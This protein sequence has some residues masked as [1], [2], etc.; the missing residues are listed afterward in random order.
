MN[1]TL[2]TLVH[3]H[4]NSEQG[5]SEKEMALPKRRQTRLPFCS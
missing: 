5:M 4:F 1:I 2:R 3:C